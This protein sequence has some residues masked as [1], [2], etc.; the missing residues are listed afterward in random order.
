MPTE[1]VTRC[2]NQEGRGGLVEDQDQARVSEGIYISWRHWNTRITGVGQDAE[3]SIKQRALV[4][5]S[6]DYQTK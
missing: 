6:K 2:L 3:L 5:K 1:S 4:K